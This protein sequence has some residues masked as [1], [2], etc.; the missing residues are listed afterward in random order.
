MCMTTYQAQLKAPQ[1]E[2]KPDTNSVN[3]E[4]NN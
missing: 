3:K 2:K 1:L 4:K